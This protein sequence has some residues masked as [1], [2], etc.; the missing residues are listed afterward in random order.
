MFDCKPIIAD[1][2][3]EAVKT[4]EGDI[5]GL[6]DQ[7]DAKYGFITTDKKK[8]PQEAVELWKKAVKQKN[9]SDAQSLYKKVVIVRTALIIVA[10]VAVIFT[11]LAIA[12]APLLGA[13]TVA[14]GAVAIAGGI[15]FVGLFIATLV[16]NLKFRKIAKDFGK[17]CV[18]RIQKLL[19]EK[20]KVK[21][22]KPTEPDLTFGRLP[23]K[24]KHQTY[25][26]KVAK[27]FKTH[28]YGKAHKETKSLAVEMSR[29]F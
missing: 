15:S 18:R 26:N 27:L 16:L 29:P 4:Y 12:G 8:G 23:D 5:T 1:Y 22:E 17:Q 21:P 24:S 2:Q 3:R 28:H 7:K 25:A 14:I 9:L 20:P 10:V 11:A 19:M 6:V 13:A